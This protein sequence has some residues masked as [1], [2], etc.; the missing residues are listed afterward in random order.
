MLEGQNT[1]YQISGRNYYGYLLGMSASAQRTFNAHQSLE[2]AVP[3]HPD[4]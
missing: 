3:T 4:T 2:I 1:D